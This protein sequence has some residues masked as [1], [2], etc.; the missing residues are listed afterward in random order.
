MN[1]RRAARDRA[2]LD[3]RLAGWQ[4]LPR[5]RPPLGWLRAV[6]ESLGMPR[7][8][9]ARRLGVTKQSVADIER[10][11]ANGTIGLDTLRR[12]AETLDCVVLYAIVPATTLEEIVDRRAREVAA[13]DLALAHHTMLLENQAASTDDRDRVIA[14]AVERAK[15]SPRLWRA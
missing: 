13:H 2:L 8:E 12:V 5:E 4:T 1:V 10:A 9:V 7:D 6:R 3:R 14:E 11:E 15:R